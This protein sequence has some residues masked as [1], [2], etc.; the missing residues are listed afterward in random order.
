M[1]TQLNQYHVV[2]EVNPAFQQTPLDLRN[3]FIRTGTGFPSGSTGLV[4][5]GSATTAAA[6]A[7]DR[8]RAPPPR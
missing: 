8:H 3:L 6:S 1:F 5:G 7:A 4:S 2:L